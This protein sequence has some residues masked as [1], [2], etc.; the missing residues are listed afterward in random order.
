MKVLLTGGSG[1]VGQAIQRIAATDFQHIELIAPTHGECD[2]A[3]MDAVRGMFDAQEFYGVIHAAAKVGGI[4][5]NM[6]DPVGF[7]VQ[8]NLINNNVILSARDAGIQRMLFMASACMYP[9]DYKNPLKEE[10]LLAAPLEPTNEAYALSK[11]VAT[12]LCEYLCEQGGLSYKTLVPCN[13]YGIGDHFGEDR[14]HLIAAAIK[15][16]WLAMQ[17][18]NSDVEIWGD[19]MVR[20][21]FLFTDDLAKFILQCLEQIE[22]LP[23]YLNIGWGSDLTVNEYYE[24][25][26]EALGYVGVFKHDLSKPAGMMQKLLDS[27]KAKTYGWAPEISMQEGIRRTVESFKALQE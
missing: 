7:L 3:D 19:G 9:R 17:N 1:M 14:S 24:M 6:D 21:E 8:N 23:N 27:S 15:K 13:L 25:V 20:R 12:K 10:Y 22:N 26:A 16:V 2:L 4:Q 18:G 11:I 5:A